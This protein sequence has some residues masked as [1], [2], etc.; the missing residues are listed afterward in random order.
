MR[1]FLTLVMPMNGSDSLLKWYQMSR[2]FVK[3]LSIT[4]GSAKKRLPQAVPGAGLLHFT[5]ITFR[6]ERQKKLGK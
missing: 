1:F 4:G 6:M 2:V 5:T 3:R